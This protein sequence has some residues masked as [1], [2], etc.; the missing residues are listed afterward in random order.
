MTLRLL[1]D[2]NVGHIVEQWLRDNGY[3]IVAVRDVDPYLPDSRIL[4]HALLDNR[5]VI[6][7]DKDFGEL[8]YRFGQG[9]SGVLLLRLDTDTSQEKI[10]ALNLILN[11]Y[12]DNLRN[13]FCVYQNGRLRIR[14]G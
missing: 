3:D 9:H 12:S 11:N 7:M 14:S 4:D 8:V 1:V 6:T 2:V 13:N 5:F 10:K